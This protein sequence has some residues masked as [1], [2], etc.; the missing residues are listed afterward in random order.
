MSDPKVGEV[1]LVKGEIEPENPF[2]LEM[3]VTRVSETIVYLKSINGKLNINAEITLVDFW[4]K[5]EI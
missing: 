5:V 4:D 3:R 2:G 1:Y